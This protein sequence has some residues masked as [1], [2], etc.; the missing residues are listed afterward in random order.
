MRSAPADQP[1]PSR[2]TRIL[3]AIF[4]V[5]G[6]AHLL[7]PRV[8]NSVIPRWVPKGRA[9]IYLSGVAELVCAAGLFTEARWA[10]P[11]S[12]AVLVGVWPANIQMAVDETRRHRSKSRQA[13]MWARVPLQLPMI[14][15]A[16]DARS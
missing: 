5:S 3:A 7:T 1:T 2:W 13:A 14:K 12:T 4:A 10:G 11:A 8:F 16:L 9:V 6:A 15:I